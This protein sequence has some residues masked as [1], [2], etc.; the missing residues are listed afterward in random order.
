M[1]GEPKRPEPDI[2]PTRPDIEPEPRPQEIPPDKNLPEKDFP[3]MQLQMPFAF[4]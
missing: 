4:R 3:P 1:T 2:P